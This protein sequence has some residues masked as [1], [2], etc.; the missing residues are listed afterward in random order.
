MTGKCRHRKKYLLV[1]HK[2]TS[3]NVL[4]EESSLSLDETNMQDKNNT[5]DNAEICRPGTIQ[6]KKLSYEEINAQTNRN[7]INTELSL[8]RSNRPRMPRNT[9]D[10][11]R[12]VLTH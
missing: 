6:I 11:S 7:H 10:S 8:R 4:N 9:L 3:T 12:I 5:T 2:S 1:Q